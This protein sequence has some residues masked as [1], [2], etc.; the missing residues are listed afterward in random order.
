M[1]E[2]HVD[3]PQHARARRER[4]ADRA[5]RDVDVG[6]RDDAG[7]GEH[8]RGDVARRPRAERGDGDRADE[9]DRDRRAERQAVD[10]EVEGD[11]HQPHRDP[12]DGDE[13]QPGGR[14]RRLPR[15]PPGGER[16][17]ARDDAQPRHARGG[18]RLEQQHRERS[19][20]VLRDRAED[21]QRLRRQPV[22]DRDGRAAR[23]AARLDGRSRKPA[24]Q[25]ALSISRVE[26]APMTTI[27]IVED[28]PAIADALAVRLRAE[29]FAV[30]VAHDGLRG[31]ELCER[32]APDLVVLDVMLPGID[33]HEVC[34]RI[35]R[36]RAGA[37]PDAHRARRGD[38]PRRRARRRRRRLH[39]QAV[40]PARARRPRAGAAAA[41]AA[42]RR[43]V[44]EADRLRL[45]HDRFRPP[46]GAPRW[47]AR[48][49]HAD[50]VR[51]PAPARAAAGDRLRPRAAA[52]GGLGLRRRQRRRA[53]RRL[54]RRRAAA[55][56]RRRRRAHRAGDRLR[57]RHDAGARRPT[58]TP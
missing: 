39:D 36:E 20:D 23:H 43:A 25:I 21:E 34:R 12:E 37:G 18:D 29:G 10:R 7:G 4:E 14:P 55:Q 26:G 15:P 17:A 32:I 8:E 40:Q 58:S 51:P 13:P 47:R 42:R 27:V 19:A 48:A 53:H 57:V 50:G 1:A 16:G 30:E 38:R 6:E 54:A 45:D 35:Q 28:E 44:V 52:R 11:V 56:A 41:R 24:V 31:V 49:P 22:G 2:D 9:L 5:A 3:R 46:R 33:G